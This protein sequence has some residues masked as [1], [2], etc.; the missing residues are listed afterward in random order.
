VLDEDITYVPELPDK[1][2]SNSPVWF[3]KTTARITG[4][5]I[6]NAMTADVMDAVEDDVDPSFKAEFDTVTPSIVAKFTKV[7]TCSIKG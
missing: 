3:A 1:V 2:M 6:G 5:D 7:L 4:S